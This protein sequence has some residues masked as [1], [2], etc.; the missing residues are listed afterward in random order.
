MKLYYLPG[1]CSL[2]AHIVLEWTGKPYETHRLSRDELKSA[3]YLRINPMG[4]VPAMVDG[5][6][7]LTQNAAVLEYLVDTHPDCGL[8]GDGTPPSRA[9]I[10]R[11]LG[12]LNSDVHKTFSLLFN[13]QRFVS[14]EAGQEELRANA[15]ARLRELFGI[16]DARLAGRQWLADRRSIADPYLYVVLRWARGK[17]V[18]L[19]GYD[20][21]GAFFERME[22][23]AGVQRVLREEGLV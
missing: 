17:G 2:A 20:N 12:F 14:G 7:T 6:E 8:M 19:S 23:D 4:V 9:E 1:A 21:L 16:A 10:R 11:W 3:E 15:S 13:P 18:D 5:G 22:N